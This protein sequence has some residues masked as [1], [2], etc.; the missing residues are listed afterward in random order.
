MPQTVMVSKSWKPDMVK[1]LMLS[2]SLNKRFTERSIV[3]SKGI[4]VKSDSI[5]K[6]VIV[7]LES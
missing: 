2:L 6:L 4:L 5:S 3:S 1:Q 7:K